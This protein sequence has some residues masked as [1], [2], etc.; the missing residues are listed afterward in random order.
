METHSLEGPLGI[1]V[2]G[3]PGS[4]KSHLARSLKSSWPDLVVLDPDLVDLMSTE[5]LAHVEKLTG[6]GIDPRIHLYRFLRERAY[7]TIDNRGVFVWNQPFTSR[8]IFDKMTA[9]L[10]NRAAEDDVK[11]K[12]LI[13]EF[14]ID[15]EI[16]Y[17]RLKKRIAHGGHGPDRQRF[18]K[19]VAD[20][21]SFA[22]SGYPTLTLSGT[23]D[24]SE[25]TKM[26]QSKIQE[27]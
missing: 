24:V 19:F 5:Y 2:R 20:Y 4:G 8:D 17:T 3:L 7:Q 10:E 18:D 6:E 9:R 13:I 15:P 22:D 21:Q 14:E 23:V 25:L 26:A 27:L 12:L 16:A 1:I 11:L